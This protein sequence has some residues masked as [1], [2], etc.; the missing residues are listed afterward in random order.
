VFGGPTPAWLRWARSLQHQKWLV[1]MA[2]WLHLDDEYFYSSDEV[3]I[4]KLDT[5]FSPI[6]D[7]R[8]DEL[9]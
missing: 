5:N 6:D 4:F 9:L 7:V 1:M 3:H 2:F 8:V